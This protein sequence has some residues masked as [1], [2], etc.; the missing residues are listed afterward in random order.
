MV[1]LYK[2][3]SLNCDF[4][5]TAEETGRESNETKTLMGNHRRVLGGGKASDTAA[6]A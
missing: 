6:G 4:Q 2:G 3:L 5:Y 1:I